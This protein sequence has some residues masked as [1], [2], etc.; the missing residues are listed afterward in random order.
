MAFHGSFCTSVLSV[1]VGADSLRND[2]RGKGG[3]G[4]REVVMCRCDKRSVDKGQ[5]IR[6]GSDQDKLRLLQRRGFSL[7]FG[8]Y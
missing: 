4:P 8:S 2:L 3:K 7:D 5:M 1:W 6:D